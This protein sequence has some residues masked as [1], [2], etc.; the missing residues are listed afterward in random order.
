MFDKKLPREERCP[1]HGEEA[2]CD[3]CR[4]IVREGK[5][6]ILK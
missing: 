1:Y 3:N 2:R 6:L 5:R 4:R